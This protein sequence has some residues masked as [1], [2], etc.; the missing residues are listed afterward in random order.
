[1][2][3][4]TPPGDF[5]ETIADVIQPDIKL[6]ARLPIFPVKQEPIETDTPDVSFEFIINIEYIYKHYIL[7]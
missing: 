2:R 3:P 7:R 6:P 4:K 5:R 1:M